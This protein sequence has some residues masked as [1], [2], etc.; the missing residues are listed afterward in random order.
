VCWGRSADGNNALPFATVRGHLEK[1]RKDLAISVVP[2]KNAG[3]K[4]GKGDLNRPTAGGRQGP[5]NSSKQNKKK[6]PP[7]LS[8]SASRCVVP[9]R[10]STFG[11]S[12]SAWRPTMHVRVVRVQPFWSRVGA[13][14]V[15]EKTL[16]TL[17][18][19]IYP[20]HGTL[21]CVVLRSRDPSRFHG[22]PIS[23]LMA[24]WSLLPQQSEA[25]RSIPS[26]CIALGVLGVFFCRHVGVAWQMGPRSPRAGAAVHSHLPQRDGGALIRWQA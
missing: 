2:K 21:L 7:V 6:A 3:K 19:S 20:P 23:P 5:T 14:S 13:S 10:K 15:R 24:R 16:S 12:L 22:R 25:R 9:R 1:K 18:Y 4:E 11:F 17:Y 26:P 8:L